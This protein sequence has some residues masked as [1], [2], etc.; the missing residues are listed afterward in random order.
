MHVTEASSTLRDVCVCVCA[1]LV[2]ATDAWSELR[3]RVRVCFP[4]CVVQSYV[5]N[6]HALLRA[7]QTCEDPKPERCVHVCIHVCTV[8]FYTFEHSVYVCMHIHA[9][10]NH[11][12][13]P[14]VCCSDTQTYTSPYVEV[15]VC[16]VAQA[17]I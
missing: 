4:I 1:W 13:E 6:L 12:L 2:A 9:V 15:S 11:N 3:R 8:W 7:V 16:C 10:R 5:W 17:N 14:L